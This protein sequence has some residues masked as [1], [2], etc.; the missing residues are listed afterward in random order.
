MAAEDYIPHLFD[1]YDDDPRNGDDMLVLDFVS[2]VAET[3]DAWRVRFVDGKY[4]K[5]DA[6]LPKSRCTKSASVGGELM[7]PRWLVEKKELDAYVS[8]D[9]AEVL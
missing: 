4:K 2:V 3:D 6:W 5:V 1:G 9:E 7:V 8:F